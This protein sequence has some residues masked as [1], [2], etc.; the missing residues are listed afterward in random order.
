M[1]R[2]YL[3]CFALFCALS[4]WAA[5]GCNPTNETQAPAVTNTLTAVFV[6]PSEAL[7]PEA[8]SVVKRVLNGTSFTHPK[9]GSIFHNRERLLPQQPTGYYREYTIPTPAV[10]NRG[11]RRL[12]TG[13]TP[14]TE[15]FYT[16]NHYRSFRRIEVKQP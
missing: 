5:F 14:P 11:A 16:D 12:V 1:M 6:P 2:S 9:D 10:R 13:G 4:L 7:P 8:N 3:Q 15:F